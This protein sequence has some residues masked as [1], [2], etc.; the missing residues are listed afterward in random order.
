MK[1]TRTFVFSYITTNG[2]VVLNCV[3]HSA[4]RAEAIEELHEGDTL[5]LVLSAVEVTD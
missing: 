3:I 4:T 5:A 2:L 1:A